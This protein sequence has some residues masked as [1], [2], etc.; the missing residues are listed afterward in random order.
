[1]TDSMDAV[2][3]TRPTRALEGDA[4][5]HETAHRLLTQ[6]LIDRG[7]PPRC[8]NEGTHGFES[9]NTALFV[10][11]LSATIRLVAKVDQ[12]RKVLNE[13][14]F[15]RRTAEDP[16]LPR[17]LRDA[18]PRVYGVEVDGPPYGYVMEYLEGYELLS[19]YLKDPVARHLVPE[20][21]GRLWAILA[22]AY[23]ATRSSRLLP[24]IAEDYVNRVDDRMLKAASSHPLLDPNIPVR[25][26]TAGEVIEMPPWR[27]LLASA[28]DAANNIGPGFTTWVFGDP[29]PDNI[30]IRAE[31]EG[32]DIKLIDPKE[33][34]RGDYLFDVAK[35]GHCLRTTL[36]VEA[37]YLARTPSFHTNAGTIEI[38]YELPVPGH[39]SNAERLLLILA[40]GLAS[41]LGDHAWALRYELGIGS[42]LL[43][44]VPRRLAHTDELQ[45]QL[46]IVA[47]AEGL[48]AI[49]GGL[50]TNN[51]HR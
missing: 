28:R 17:A 46:G 21:L 34:E 30:L 51:R 7:L 20:I 27:D 9:G 26:T 24:N 19:N 31:G 35:M 25:V 15:L 41:A 5:A 38:A 33:W 43:G 10:A 12:S 40:G 14:R 29:N 23:R 45:N 49:H 42:N 32:Y 22:E 2:D 50:Q 39:Y 48:R 11:A 36:P 37:G 1:M 16:A 18:V 8:A 3:G 47:F 13:G 4:R 6:A 44:N